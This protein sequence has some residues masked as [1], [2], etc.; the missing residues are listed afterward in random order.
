MQGLDQMLKIVEGYLSAAD[1]GLAKSAQM[2]ADYT[3]FTEQYTGAAQSL[4]NL[5]GAV[6]LI[7][8]ELAQIR[9]DLACE[10]SH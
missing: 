5:Q 1:M 9:E 8:Q 4:T 7:L 10:R 3:A 2:V 6:S